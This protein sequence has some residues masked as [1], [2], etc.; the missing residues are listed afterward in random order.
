MPPSQP[1]PVSQRFSTTSQDEYIESL[2]TFSSD[3]L[4]QTLCG[5]IHILDFF[6][7]DS[8]TVPQ[9][10]Y[11]TVIPED[12]IHYFSTQS[13]DHVL[14]L[15]LRIPRSSFSTDVPPT[16][17]DYIRNVR[18]HTLQR[19]FVRRAA[20]E[21][22]KKTVRYGTEWALNAGMRPKKI[23]EVENF[24]AFLDDLVRDIQATDA[25]T[26]GSGIS[27]VV[28][29]GSGQAYLSRTMA[30]KYGHSVVGIESRTV[31]IEGAKTLDKMFDSIAVKKLRYK[32]RTGEC[33]PEGEPPVVGSLQYVQTYISNGNL[34]EV[35]EAIHGVTPQTTGVTIP[36]ND[37]VKHSSNATV[38]INDSTSGELAQPDDPSSATSAGNLTQP[39]SLLLTSLHSCGNLV[40]HALSA[41]RNTPSVRAVALIG[42]CYNLLTEKHGASWKPPFLRAPHPRLISTS[43][44]DDPHGFPISSHL[45][46]LDIQFNITARSMACQAPSNWTPT[47]SSDFFLRHFYRA[48]LQRIFLDKYLITPDSTE[49]IIIGSL[50][51]SSYNSFFDYFTAA[52]QKLGWAEKCPLSKEESVEYEQ[53]FEGRRKELEVVWSL[54][55]FSAGVVESVIVVDRWLFLKEMGC[56]NAWVE[57]A[58][59]HKESPRNFVVVGIGM[60]QNTA[61]LRDLSRSGILY[62]LYVVKGRVMLTVWYHSKAFMGQRLQ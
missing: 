53:R 22:T 6:T 21:K 54:M 15:L 19:D 61:W 40:H 32:R 16:L 8:E 34:D 58:F 1:L 4:L 55:A 13:T 18:D 31:N 23:H 48:L 62:D 57:A 56:R 12:W 52:V 42:C 2:L 17:K 24:A 46:S 29:Y 35:V 45:T 26:G 51:K 10:I 14:D 43:T 49:P 33:I 59:E 50:R 37:E 39:K 5:G 44:A 36:T 3:P 47:S 28:D 38:Q 20:S 30:K 41:F 7:R 9:D 25:E 27:H 11:R 60:I